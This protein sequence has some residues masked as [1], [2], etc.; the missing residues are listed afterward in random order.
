I[1][2]FILL[3]PSIAFAQDG[4]KVSRGFWAGGRSHVISH[5]ADTDEFADTSLVIEA[6]RHA[7][8]VYNRLWGGVDTPLLYIDVLATPSESR[9]LADA[10]R[11][12]EGNVP[13]P[14]TQSTRTHEVCAG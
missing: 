7:L 8:P 13:V 12:R 1:L 6:A 4:L 3:A 2:P 10:K 11:S 14:G 5:P 9:S